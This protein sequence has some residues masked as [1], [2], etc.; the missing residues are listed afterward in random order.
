MLGEVELELGHYSAAD[1]LFSAVR[2]DVDQFAV[3]ARMARWR[4]LTG[5]AA[6]ARAILR[7][8]IH[9]IASRDDLPRE[10]RAWFHYRLAELDART[11]RWA[12]ADSSYQRGLKIFPDDYRILAGLAHLSA[13]R[14][15]WAQAV[16]Y[17]ERAI[18]IQLDPTVLG[19]VSDAYRQLGEP[20][21]AAQYARAMRVSALRQPG[22]IHRAWGLF[23]L[24]H[25]TAVERARVLSK[26]RAEL[27]TRNDVY[28]YDLL[29][30]GL[31]RT[32]RVAEAREPMAR[33]L[34]QRTEDPQLFEHAAEI[35]IA[36][37]NAALA[38]DYRARAAAL[39]GS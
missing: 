27:R 39:R 3:A 2:Y 19:I 14:Q 7:R 36:S 8:C 29:A 10:Q 35:E 15:Q 25:G 4:E 6:E 28:G 38:A 20:D 30:W 32:G 37:G 13:L 9:R 1:S 34:A 22:P 26:A 5:H 12:A 21:R 31:F 23:V 17:G 16:A 33:A 18:A 11:G 24:D